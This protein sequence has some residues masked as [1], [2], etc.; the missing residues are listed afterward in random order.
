MPIRQGAA[1]TRSI[2]GSPQI[3]SAKSEV[4]WAKKMSE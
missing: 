1:H 3:L 2:L 4:I